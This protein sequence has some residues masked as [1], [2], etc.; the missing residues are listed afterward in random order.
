M[1]PTEKIESEGMT[2]QEIGLLLV[3]MG[4][5]QRSATL[6]A[7]D[8]H[9]FLSPMLVGRRI[10]ENQG[11]S[12]MEEV[13]DEKGWRVSPGFVRRSFERFEASG[14]VE[15]L[16][17]THKFRLSA[18]GET[19][20]L[21]FANMMLRYSLETGV[22]PRELFSVGSGT[23]IDVECSDG[24]T[25]QVPDSVHF[26]KLDLLRVL[27]KE[28]EPVTFAYLS[29][30]LGIEQINL[31]EMVR[32]ISNFGFV[33][34]EI[35]EHG[36]P[37]STYALTDKAGQVLEQV[38]KGEIKLGLNDERNRITQDIAQ[39]LFLFMNQNKG[40]IWNTD[41]LMEYI[42]ASSPYANKDRSYDTHITSLVNNLGYLKDIGLVTITNERNEVSLNPD[43]LEPIERLFEL[44]D[45]F[46]Q[47]SRDFPELTQEELAAIMNMARENSPAVMDTDLNVR[48]SSIHTE[49]NQIFG[50]EGATFRQ[51]FNHLRGT[52]IE[53]A[54]SEN[55]IARYLELLQERGLLRAEGT[56]PK[57]YFTLSGA[58]LSVAE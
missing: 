11:L 14:L 10:W 4:L 25:R 57:K 7:T 19:V 20:A 22:D 15:R 42:V 23:M 5:I 54:R 21:P 12:P 24:Q 32:E 37:T 27:L 55:S 39:E 2:D 33:Y 8:P 1:E 17:G 58:N 41:D 3:N 38:L 40:K 16:E 36:N 6:S 9:T 48:L 50:A 46:K 45:A 34:H 51:I 31:T 30:Q 52:N 44:L 43:M 26:R 49:I 47:G 13:E 35:I 28:P 53:M 56:K 29:D 18:Y